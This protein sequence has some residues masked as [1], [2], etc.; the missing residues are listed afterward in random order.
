MPGASAGPTLVV[1]SDAKAIL[2]ARE[3]RGASGRKSAKARGA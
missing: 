2:A 1:G 3:L